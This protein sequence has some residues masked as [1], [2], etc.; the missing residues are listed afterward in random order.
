MPTVA[1]FTFAL[2]RYFDVQEKDGSSHFH[3]EG[4]KIVICLISL[5]FILEIIYNKHYRVDTPFSFSDKVPNIAFT[6]HFQC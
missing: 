1:I 5:I 4:H 6:Y 3:L 2:I